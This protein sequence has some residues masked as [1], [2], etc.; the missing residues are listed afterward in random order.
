M[1]I[2]A[3]TKRLGYSQVLLSNVIHCRAPISADMAVRL[4]RARLGK[5]HMW[6]ARQSVYD[7]WQAE[8]K[9]N[10]PAIS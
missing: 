9:D 4:D 8:H 10:I 5:A 6:L 2:T 1:V 7:L 3:L